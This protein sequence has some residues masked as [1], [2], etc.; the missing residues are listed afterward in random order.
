MNANAAQGEKIGN[1]NIPT[2]MEYRVKTKT[3]AKFLNR[4]VLNASLS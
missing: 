4:Y 2:V 3:I 1:L